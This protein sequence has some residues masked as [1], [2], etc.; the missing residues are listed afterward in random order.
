MFKHISSRETVVEVTERRASGTIDFVEM[1][2]YCYEKEQIDGAT[3][4][5]NLLN[6][7]YILVIA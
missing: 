6:K 1:T 2:L 5:K 3:G 4:K 7:G